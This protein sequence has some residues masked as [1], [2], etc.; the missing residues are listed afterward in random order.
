MIT[1]QDLVQAGLYPN[2]QTVI[3]EAL[4]VL[5]QERPHLRIEW[6]IYQYQTQEISLGKAAA[7]AGVCFDR[8]K[9]I[10]MQRAIQPRLGPETIAE[11]RQ[12]LEVV[13]Q[14]LAAGE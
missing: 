14:S 5:W 10:L 2:E 8:M 11:A 12:E 6:A 13:E 9:E 3:K 7:I 4:Q 1:P